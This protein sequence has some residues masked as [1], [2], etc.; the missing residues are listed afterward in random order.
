MDE[1]LELI[2][3][4]KLARVGKCNFLTKPWHGKCESLCPWAG[5]GDVCDAEVRHSVHHL[6]DDHDDVDDDFDDNEDE[7]DFSAAPIIM[8]VTLII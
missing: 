8:I 6:D 4:V 5:Y 3:F 2:T 1:V 7:D